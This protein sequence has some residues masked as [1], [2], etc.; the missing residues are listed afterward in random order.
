M[1]LVP[2]QGHAVPRPFSPSARSLPFLWPEKMQGLFLC[3]TLEW[4]LEAW[5]LLHIIHTV[6]LHIHSKGQC[7]Q[8]P[9]VQF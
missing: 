8:S 6:K 3:R 1:G 2:L 4:A 9:P 7:I 5:D